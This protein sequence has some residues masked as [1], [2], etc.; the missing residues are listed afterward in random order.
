MNKAEK[1]AGS[2]RKRLSARQ[3]DISL[4]DAARDLGF[5]GLG[6][7]LALLL[8]P[9][10]VGGSS[11]RE[12]REKGERPLRSR[13][14]EDAVSP[15][16][17][18][19]AGW[20]EIAKRTYYEVD[21]DRV[22][23]VAAGV[24]FY[25]LLAVFP[26]LA[27]FISLY[28]LIASPETVVEHLSILA[29]IMPADAYELLR[30][31]SLK[32][33]S[34]GEG[35][36]GMSLIISLALSIWSA[37]AGMKAV[38]DALNVAYGE[39]EKRGFV[40]LNLISLAF[41]AGVLIFALVGGFAVIAVPLL[42]EWLYLGPV[43]EPIIQVGRWP[44]L[45]VVLAAGLSV[46]YRFGPSRDQAQWRWV[47]PGAI[48]AVLVWISASI[49]FSWYVANFENYDKTYGTVGAAIGL[50]MWM[51]ISATIIL[52][53]AELNAESER[54]TDRDTT[55]GPPAPIGLRGA[56]VADRKQ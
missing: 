16:Q 52:V 17:I 48:V 39:D 11:K 22:L 43:A 34:Q 28:G 7:A 10:L 1:Q 45:I 35:K 53:G 3:L 31:Q 29:T 30:E 51:W 2:V 9:G 25:G 40:A 47:S 44:M 37:N 13:N 24:T 18:P 41:T 55:R 56:D 23:A 5:I 4:R 42:L 38:F 14:G 50:M 32:L 27:A 19:P 54:Q 15:T 49:S 21:R 46:L 33:S 6:A 20:Y 12:Q 36:L 26:A 8:V